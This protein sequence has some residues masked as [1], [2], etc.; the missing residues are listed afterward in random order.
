MGS[1]AT[2]IPAAQSAP[3]AEMRVLSEGA[4]LLDRSERG[5]LALEGPEAIEFLNGQVTNELAGLQPGEGRYAAFLTHKGKMLGDLRVLA[6]REGAGASE[7][8]T[9]DTERATLQALF[10][11][12][13]RF[14]VGYRVELHKR[15]L[16]RGLLSLIGPRAAAVAGV[17][18]LAADEHSNAPVEI[19]GVEALAVRTDVGIDLFCEAIRRESLAGAAPPRGARPSRRGRR[20]P[21]HRTRPPRYG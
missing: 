16:E 10:D 2:D 9:L 11:M 5:K 7:I 20:V 4:G 6:V 1:A 18:G 15:T 19:D 12:I 13:L 21:A 14:K 8:L 17:E 3:A